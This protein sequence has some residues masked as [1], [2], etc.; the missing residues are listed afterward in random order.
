M[1]VRFK[2]IVGL[3]VL[4][5]QFCTPC[6]KGDLFS[7]S[8]KSLLNDQQQEAVRTFFMA[9]MLDASRAF[10]A[11]LQD[12]VFCKAIKTSLNNPSAP[13]FSRRGL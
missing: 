12:P 3:L 11:Y 9:T 13:P 4:L 7:F 2:F 5:I 10:I 6:L 8:K 1:K